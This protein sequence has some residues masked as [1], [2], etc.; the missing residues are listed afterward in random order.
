MNLNLNNFIRSTNKTEEDIPKKKKCQV[1]NGQADLK[2]LLIKNSKVVNNDI[3]VKLLILF[4][5]KKKMPK[6]LKKNITEIN[7]IP[8]PLEDKK[9]N[10]SLLNLTLVTKLL[11]IPLSGNGIS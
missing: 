6:Q 7:F 11:A 8:Y 5:N 1:H 10:V 2:L 9:A 3:F 4:E